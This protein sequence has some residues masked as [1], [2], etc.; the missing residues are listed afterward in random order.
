MEKIEI[1]SASY[2]PAIDKAVDII[3]RGGVVIYPTDTVYGLAVEA[4]DR[5][6][7]ERLIK[8]KGR[9]EGKPIPVIVKDIEMAGK[10]A[11]LNS[12]IEKILR[13][14]WPGPVTVVLN[15]RPDLPVNLTANSGTIGLRIPDYQPARDLVSRLNKPITATS[16][17]L[18]GQPA[19]TEISRIIDQFKDRNV[20]PDLILD[21]GDLSAGQPSTVIDIRGPKLRILRIGPVNKEQLLKILQ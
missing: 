15:S 3:G 14:V 13:A 9:P 10:L 7:V 18:S 5:E 16:A 12:R 2:W 8:I 19:L 17:N 11:Y 20:Q 4:L 6:A 21:V 1:N